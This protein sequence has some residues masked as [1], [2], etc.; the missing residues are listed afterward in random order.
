MDS[1]FERL[2]DFLHTAA[3]SLPEGGSHLLVNH[4]KSSEA[5]LFVRNPSDPRPGFWHFVP[6]DAISR[7]VWTGESVL[8]PGGP[9]PRVR[10]LLAEGRAIWPQLILFLEGI[11]CRATEDGMPPL[12]EFYAIRTGR[13]SD[14]T[15]I[16]KT[17]I[18][19]ANRY[20]S[21]GHGNHKVGH[22]VWKGLL[23]QPTTISLRCM[24]YDEPDGDDDL[25]RFRIEFWP[26]AQVPPCFDCL[27]KVQGSITPQLDSELLLPDQDPFQHNLPVVRLTGDGVDYRLWFSYGLSPFGAV[28][29]ERPVGTTN[30]VAAVQTVSYYS[31]EA[32]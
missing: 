32:E 28:D 22:L 27:A 20:W 8:C 18:P 14:G 1:T 19:A 26:V 13:R 7:L 24:E 10:L 9:F 31:V 16:P 29:A 17:F 15:V 25:G 12:D 11:Q 5:G 30:D 21:I 4:H 6:A 2:G 23:D 3:D